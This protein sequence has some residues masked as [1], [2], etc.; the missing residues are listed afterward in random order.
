MVLGSSRGRGSVGTTISRANLDICYINHLLCNGSHST[1]IHSTED[2]EEE[3]YFTKIVFV[4]YK[5]SLVK[6]LGEVGI[7]CTY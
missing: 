5:L 6:S 4:F 2:D 3:F 7:C 1:I